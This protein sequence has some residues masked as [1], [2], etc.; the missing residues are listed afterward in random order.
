MKKI[1]LLVTMVLIVAFATAQVNLSKGLMAYYPFTGN[2]NDSSG[3]SNNPSFNN[4]TL[5][6]IDLEMLIVRITLMDNLPI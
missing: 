1:Y 5:L 2:A 4:A 3:N 6:L